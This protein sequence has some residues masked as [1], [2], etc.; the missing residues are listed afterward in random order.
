M[1]WESTETNAQ[2]FRVEYV[3]SVHD[4]P[5]FPTSRL[6]LLWA[7]FGKG[8]TLWFALSSFLYILGKID[9]LTTARAYRY[10][11]IASTTV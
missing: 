1:A 9:A 5:H 11:R 3:D 8:L 10:E 6:C 7:S 4:R 2:L